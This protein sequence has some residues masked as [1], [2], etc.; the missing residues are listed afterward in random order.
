MLNTPFYTSRNK[1][2]HLIFC[3]ILLPKIIIYFYK[4][5]RISLELIYTNY[6]QQSEFG[7]SFLEII[8]FLSLGNVRYNTISDYC[9]YKH[10]TVQ[11]KIN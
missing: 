9:H 6:N 11:Q 5:N 3:C 1:I 7:E 8:K 10:Y 4:F 2:S